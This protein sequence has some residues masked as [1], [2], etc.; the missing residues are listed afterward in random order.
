MLIFVAINNQ[1]RLL[2]HLDSY[3]QKMLAKSCI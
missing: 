2:S 3:V 1:M